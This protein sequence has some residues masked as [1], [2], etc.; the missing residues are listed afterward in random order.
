MRL[1]QA[2]G[3]FY[4][5]M[6]LRWMGIVCLK[7]GLSL[8]VAGGLSFVV[9]FYAVMTIGINTDT[10]N[11]LS[12][13]LPF[14]QN[15]EAHKKTFP[16]HSGTLA[17]LVDAETPGFARKVASD[18]TARL[19]AEP[20]IFQDVFYSGGHSFFLRNGLLYLSEEELDNLAGRLE[21]ASPFL[22]AIG[23]NP[24]LRS[25]TGVL[26]LAI[27]DAVRESSDETGTM[28]GIAETLSEIAKNL[29]AQTS[30]EVQQMDWGRVFGVQGQEK[31][32]QIITTRPI[33]N[34]QSLQPG[35]RAVKK[36]REIVADLG[37]DQNSMVSIRQT[38]AAALAYEE[39]KSVESNIGFVGMLSF[40]LVGFML[41]IGL[42]S[43]QLLLATLTML[44]VGLIWTAGF[45][46]LFIGELNLISV[47]FA[48]LF[49]GLGVDAGIH[50]SLRYREECIRRSYNP[51]NN[52]ALNATGAELAMPLGLC[53]VSTVIAFLSFLPTSYRGLSELGMISGAGMVIALLATY[54]VLPAFLSLFPLPPGS[55]RAWAPPPAALK[56]QRPRWPERHPV[57]ILLGT[58][59]F[60]IFALSLI[61]DVR[62]DFDPMNLRDPETESVQAFRSLQE[63]SRTNPYHAVVVAESLPEANSL[64]NQLQALPE[65]ASTLTLADYVPKNQEEK[66]LVIQDLKDFIGPLLIPNAQL[67]AEDST[68]EKRREALVNLAARLALVRTAETRLPQD[69]DLA[70]LELL[71]AIEAFQPETA[72]PEALEEA[73]QR[74]V[75]DLSQR[76][77]N[78]RMALNASVITLEGMPVVLRER[79]LSE[80]GKARIEV[81]PS[82]SLDTIEAIERFVQT[83]EKLAPNVTGTP[84]IVYAA[85]GAVIEAFEDAFFYA[86][87]LIAPLLAFALRSV[88]S[89][90]LVLAPLG[91]AGLATV[92]ASIMLDLPFNFANAIVLPLLVGLGVDSGIHVVTRAKEEIN[93]R[94]GVSGLLASSTPRAVVI[95]SLTTIGSFGT[96][97]LS[98]HRGTASMGELLAIAV[99]LTLVSTLVILPALLT[100]FAP[101][102]DYAVGAKVQKPSPEGI[103]PPS[104]PDRKGRFFKN[105]S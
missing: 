21:G 101:K 78:L 6:I 74:I 26:G 28:S 10:T 3:A 49:I 41:W 37:Y 92:S 16:V 81:Y 99:V 79:M 4:K 52:Q 38:G 33:T 97:A 87:L 25:L 54:S 56:A 30:G 1:W 43:W 46:A 50:F 5:T 90:F 17:I 34:H 91:V 15:Y 44:V 68:D 96:L 53:T 75:G 9:L 31:T 89:A 95:S 70:T 98:S 57:K 83:I 11:M 59:A 51:Q 47:A 48:V 67:I 2:V 85:G 24:T 102:A 86:L 58:V 105:R 8:S 94:K 60:V 104:R 71:R 73:S 62:F 19:L 20:Q 65:I 18:I 63:D 80:D 61:G 72:S 22:G 14:R 32:R 64:A 29:Q 69:L 39:T 7:P 76:L 84:A 12:E 45:A 55:V 27:D 13:D 103:S 82:E 36:V 35:K 23:Q 66:I 93:S 88:R 100:L 77:T 40:V 42:R